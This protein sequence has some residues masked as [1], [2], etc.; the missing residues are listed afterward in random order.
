MNKYF[1]KKVKVNGIVFD[2]K[3]E[4]MR[5]LYLF[6]LQRKGIIKDL[7]RQKSFVLIPAQREPEIR[8]KNGKNK[9]GRV[10]ERE[11]RYIA[12]F[13]YKMACSGEIVVEDTKGV[14]TKDYILKRKM[15]L[16]FY[17]IKIKEI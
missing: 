8:L 4:A 16:Y 3:K 12:D 11:I 2:S 5:Y 17:G 6:S 14:K 1:N 10:I 15:M 13:V 9:Q 7:E